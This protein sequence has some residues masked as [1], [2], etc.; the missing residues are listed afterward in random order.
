[1]SSQLWWVRAKE[2]F[3]GLGIQQCHPRYK[4]GLPNFGT[5]PVL[6]TGEVSRFRSCIQGLWVS[7]TCRGLLFVPACSGFSP[8]AAG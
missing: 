4:P 3:W 1:M 7:Q 2:V 6:Y 8:R 5:A